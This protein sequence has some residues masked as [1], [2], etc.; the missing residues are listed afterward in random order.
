MQNPTH[1]MEPLFER[2]QEYGKTSYELIRLKTLDKAV[3]F[4]STFASRVV[5][6]FVLSLFLLFGSIGLSLWLGE[7][8]GKIYFGFFCV[9]GFYLFLGSVLF[10]FFKNRIKNYFSN[11]IVSHLFN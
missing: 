6:I 8:L 5:V 10:F 1:I 2:V 9:A 11:S 3:G 4:L 7:L